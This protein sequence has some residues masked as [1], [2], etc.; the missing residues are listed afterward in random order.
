MRLAAQVAVEH[1]ENRPQPVSELDGI[2]DRNGHFVTHG[3]EIW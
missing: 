2:D 3:N 1:Q